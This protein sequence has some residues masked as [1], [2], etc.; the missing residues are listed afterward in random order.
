MQIEEIDIN[1]IIPYARNQKIHN[2][3]QIEMIARSIEKYG[4]VQ[5]LVIDK[6]N[7]IVIGHGRFEASKILGLDTIPCYRAE[8]LTDKQIKELRI[9]DNKLNESEWDA[10]MLNTELKDFD[11]DLGEFGID[12]Q[13]MLE[14]TNDKIKDLE[15]EQKFE[16]IVELENEEE[17]QKFYN[18]MLE[19][20]YNVKIF[21]I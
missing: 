13:E 15:L 14:D 9:V 12:L 16:V 20:G 17:Q 5:P 6:N 7:N 11:L 2:Q 19:K 1:K 18:E 21:S 8:N 4:F 10:E 3:K